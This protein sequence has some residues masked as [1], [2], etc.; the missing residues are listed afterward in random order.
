MP[1]VAFASLG[2]A[3]GALMLGPDFRGLVIC[4]WS[5][6]SVPIILGMT[7]TLL[8]ASDGANSPV[9]LP[10]GRRALATTVG[11]VIG[12]FVL[13]AM[14]CVTLYAIDGLGSAIVLSGLPIGILVGSAL[15]VLAAYQTARILSLNLNWYRCKTCGARFRARYATDRCE[16]CEKRA[17]QEEVA[18]ALAGLAAHTHEL[19]VREPRTGA[20]G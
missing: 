19:P 15:G 16:R 2:P 1:R 4:F 14:V 9:R 12:P 3:G 18:R 5:V 13:A 11:G 7:A 17:E 20:T 8:A 6:L 10:R